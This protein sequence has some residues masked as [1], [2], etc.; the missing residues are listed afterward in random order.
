MNNNNTNYK[1]AL[2]FSIIMIILITIVFG[3]MTFVVNG[4]D[5]QSYIIIIAAI[6]LWPLSLIF[7]KK[8]FF[9]IQQIANNNTAE[10]SKNVVK[11]PLVLSIVVW[12][13]L[14]ALLLGFNL[15]TVGTITWAIYPISGISLFPIGMIIYSKL[16]ER[17]VRN[18]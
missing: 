2:Q 5:V 10:I 11:V 7:S 12:I 4:I 14:T 3:V 17:N 9:R 8:S 1:T 13:V 16:Y 18:D 15:F 6:L